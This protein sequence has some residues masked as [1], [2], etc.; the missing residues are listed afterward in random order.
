MRADDT[1]SSKNQANATTPQSETHLIWSVS[2]IIDEHSLL[3]VRGSKGRQR[4][5]LPASAN[6]ISFEGSKAGQPSISHYVLRSLTYFS[7]GSPGLSTPHMVHS[8]REIRFCALS[9]RSAAQKAFMLY[10]LH[11]TTQCSRGANQICLLERMCYNDVHLYIWHFKNTREKVDP[12]TTESELVASSD[13]PRD[14]QANILRL[15]VP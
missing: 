6:C 14:N 15:T 12:V 4:L 13:K 5:T 10:N 2:L 9:L 11:Q 1:E 7:P 3:V 8:N